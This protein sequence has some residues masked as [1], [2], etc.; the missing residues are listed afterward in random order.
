M[1]GAKDRGYRTAGRTPGRTSGRTTD[2]TSGRTSGRTTDRTGGPTDGS[3]AGRAAGRTRARGVEPVVRILVAVALAVDAYVHFTLAGAMQLA[4]PEGIGG[5]ALFRIQGGAA[6]VAALLVLVAGSRLAY[7][8]A[9]LVALS[10]L[11][12]V[13]L[14]SFVNVPAVGPI[15][16]MYDPTWYPLKVLSVVAAAVGV[17]LGLLGFALAGRRVVSERG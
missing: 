14:Y 9:V 17:L 11:G 2:R 6:A 8:V 1:A 10:A 13:L 15:P 16:S 7:A 12:P 3:I 5:A 4:A